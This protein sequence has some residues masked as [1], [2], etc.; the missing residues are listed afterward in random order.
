[1]TREELDETIEKYRNL[2]IKLYPEDEVKSYQYDQFSSWLED[3]IE[4][5]DNDENNDDE[6]DLWFQFKEQMQESENFDDM[7][8]EGDEDDSITDW[9]TKD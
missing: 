2:S 7:F 9:I 5:Y 3:N 8:P 4:F 6:E 1:M